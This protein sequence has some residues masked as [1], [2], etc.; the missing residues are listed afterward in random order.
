MVSD[1]LWFLTMPYKEKLKTP[2]PKPRKKSQYKVTNW[3]EY[4]KSLKKR[5]E[6]SLYFPGGE[7]KPYFINNTSY[8]KGISG[9]QAIYNNPI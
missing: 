5:R 6:V 1:V 9:Q 8:I 4:N 7:L 3:T 2:S